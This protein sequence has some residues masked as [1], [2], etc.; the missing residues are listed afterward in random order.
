V[1]Q[2][3]IISNSIS[4]LITLLVH[5]TV[6]TV[7]IVIEVLEHLKPLVWKHK[8]Y[9][10]QHVHSV[11]PPS[12][13]TSTATTALG[14][15]HRIG[16]FT[17]PSWYLTFQL[18]VR[19]F[20]SLIANTTSLI[21]IAVVVVSLIVFFQFRY[22]LHGEHALYEWTMM[23]N[24]IALSSSFLSRMLSYAQSHFWYVFKLC[25]PKYLCFDYGFDCIPMVHSVLDLRNFFP[26]IVYTAL[27]VLIIHTLQHMRISLMLG[28]ATFILPL[29]PALNIFVAVGT[30]LAERLLFIP[31]IGFCWLITEVLLY[32]CKEFWDGWDTWLFSLYESVYITVK[33]SVDQLY[34]PTSPDKSPTLSPSGIAPLTSPPRKVKHDTNA[35][36]VK[37]PK[38]SDRF[39][40][41]FYLFF[42]PF[43]VACMFR[44]TTRN[45]D[46]ASEVNIYSSA[47]RVCPRSVKAL[48]N[49]ALLILSKGEIE[50]GTI[51][52]LKAVELLPKH[53]AGLVNGGVA[54]QRAK[55]FLPSIEMYEY[56]LGTT[57]RGE[58]EGS[59]G[60]SSMKAVG[61]LGNSLYSWANQLNDKVLAKGIISQ[62]IFWLEEGMRLG[63]RAPA[64]LH[65]AGSAAF[66]IGN[67]PMAIKFYESALEEAE[68]RRKMRGGSSD[69]PI[70]DDINVVY[71]FNQL[72]NCYT[73]LGKIEEGIFYYEQGLK[74]DP[75][76]VAILSNLSILYK[77]AKQ[78]EKARKALLAGIEA[79]KDSIAPG[80]LYNNLGTLELDVGNYPL[81]LQYFEKALEC[82][83]LNKNSRTYE[84]EGGTDYRYDVEGDNVE[85]VILNNIADTRSRMQRK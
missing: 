47:L 8:T 50:K 14:A 43:V 41:S 7:M 51:T 30:V 3:K 77:E 73:D 23:E 84:M 11:T 12:L 61:Y 79:T 85:I 34:H 29:I 60:A 65:L 82:V 33:N 66:D 25:Y 31:S 6:F 2:V 67:I 15:E 53:T 48:S 4:S 5:F 63:F 68:V 52:A 57:L 42:V 20:Q 54:Y 49:Y 28:L 1:L 45:V 24:H 44:V 76:S 70:E 13:I 80:S 36:V 35:C 38:P 62:A 37:V 16:H 72:G 9:K 69:V 74:H 78:Y 10:F 27:I 75:N 55:Q 58:N 17:N 26:L 18:I 19:G 71:T 59:A 39:F 22:W 21:R 40:P 81:A 56:A 83:R 46:W 64:V 32:D